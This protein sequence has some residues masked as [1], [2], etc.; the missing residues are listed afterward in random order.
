MPGGI[1]AGV[2]ITLDP[3]WKEMA[4]KTTLGEAK[5]VGAAKDLLPLA[6]KDTP[7]QSAAKHPGTLAYPQ[8]DSQV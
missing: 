6:S 2:E 3:V 5:E 1:E 4:P 8:P 7:A